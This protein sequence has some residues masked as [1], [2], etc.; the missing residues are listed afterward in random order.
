VSWQDPLPTLVAVAI[1]AAV[2]VGGYLLSRTI[3]ER[4]RKRGA[5]AHYV[6]GTRIAIRVVSI[7]VAVAILAIELQSV[8]LV[9]GLTISAIAGLA[10]TYALQTTIQN[11]IAGYILLRNRVLRL[12]DQIQI[13]DISGKVVQLGLVSTW[14]RLDDGG[15][16]TVSNSTRLNG[17]MLNRSVGDRLKGEYWSAPRLSREDDRRASALGAQEHRRELE[18]IHSARL[19]PGSLWAQVA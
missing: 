8:P 9:S 19:E 14:L 10:V 1:A 11:M 12:N 5:A 13:N 7:S 16:A 6:R 17:P 4:L 3:A 2:A 18:S 15:F